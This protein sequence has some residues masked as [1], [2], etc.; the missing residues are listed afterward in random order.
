MVVWWVRNPMKKI[1][2]ES[3]TIQINKQIQVVGSTSVLFFDF[4]LK[5]SPNLMFQKTPGNP[6]NS[7][8]ET[9]NTPVSERPSGATWARPV[10]T[11]TPGVASTWC[12]STELSFF[13]ISE[14]NP[15]VFPKVWWKKT[16]WVVVWYQSLKAYIAKIKAVTYLNMQKNFWLY[17]TCSYESFWLRATCSML[18]ATVQNLWL[19]K[20][21]LRNERE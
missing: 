21:I 15:L 17:V 8:I 12:I 14:K 2:K 3:W 20:K 7:Y 5:K 9:L 13:G 18:L 10:P 6:G 1:R 19:G 4:C 16:S 11:E